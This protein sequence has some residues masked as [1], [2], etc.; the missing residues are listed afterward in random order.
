MHS[1]ISKLILIRNINKLLYLD[2]DRQNQLLV[3]FNDSKTACC[4]SGGML[5]AEHVCKPNSMLCA[6]RKAMFFW[7]Q[8]HPTET[9][10]ELGAMALYGGGPQHVSPMNIGEL[11]GFSYN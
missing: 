8:Y 3:G 10:Y 11:A 1:V 6:D 7:D 9:A 2:N 4:G 5:N